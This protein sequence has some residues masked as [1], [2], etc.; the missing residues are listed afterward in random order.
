[1]KKILLLIAFLATSLTYSQKKDFTISGIIKSAEDKEMLESA[2]VHVERLKDSS[3]V[4]YTITDAK[5]DFKIVSNT[6]DSKLK[7]VVSFI[8]FE[9]YSKIIDVKNQNVGTLYLKSANTLDAIVIRS[10]A[11]ITIKKDT[12]EFNVKSFK[13]KADANVEDLLKKLPG[14]EVD[15]EGTITVNGKEVN[16]ILVNGKPFFG[17]DPTIT[18]RNLTK[19]IIEKIQISD[20]KTNAQAFAGEDSDGENKT[21]NLTIKKENNKGYFGKVAAGIGTDD[22]YEYA[23]LGTRFEQSERIGLLAGGNNINSP[24]FSFGNQRLRFGG[25]NRSFGGGQGIITSNNYG[26]NYINVFKKIFEF[27]GDYFYKNSESKNTSSNNRETFLSN[28]ESFFR[29][30]NS[31]SVNESD[32][33]DASIDFEIEIDSTFRIDIESDFNKNLNTNTFNSISESLNNDRTLTNDSETNSVADSDRNQFDNEINFSKRF[34]SKGAFIRAEVTANF[35]DN[36]TDDFV[37]SETNIYGSN[38]DQIIRNQYSDGKTEVK[39][40][41]SEFTYRLPIM[42][43]KLFLDVAYAYGNTKRKQNVVLSILIKLLTI[44]QVLVLY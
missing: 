30:S 31:N 22:R 24:G 29:N 36:K 13:T 42:A 16:K 26:V 17:N 27:S 2:T 39:E 19:E 7:L 43:N 18:T 9:S 5:G 35:S 32:S 1:M 20:T 40:I 10:S 25:N 28:G 23:G 34:G 4:S 44:L 3:I 33:H 37:K 38:P 8:G 41:G 11:P 6:G 15:A 14:V 12:V 21:I